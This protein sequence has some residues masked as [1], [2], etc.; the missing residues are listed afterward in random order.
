MG[1]R[2]EAILVNDWRMLNNE[3]QKKKKICFSG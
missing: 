3:I 1:A 2:L